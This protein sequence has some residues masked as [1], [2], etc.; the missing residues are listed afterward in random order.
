[1]KNQVIKVESIEHGKRVL[2]YFCSRATTVKSDINYKK[3]LERYYGTGDLY[4]ISDGYH[5]T[6][7]SEIPEGFE[8]ITLPEEKP[9]PK[10]MMVW[11]DTNNG[12]KKLVFGCFNGFYMT[13]NDIDSIDQIGLSSVFN[14]EF[15]MNAEDIPEKIKV[16][17][18][19]IAEWKGVDKDLIEIV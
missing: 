10:M 19:E 12:I 17:L 4:I 2:E 7:T 6:I 18:E 1:M 14:V 9:Y 15:Y 5:V 3:S 8:L 13:T 16:T 11:D